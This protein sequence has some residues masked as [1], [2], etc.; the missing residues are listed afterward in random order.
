MLISF[1]SIFSYIFYYKKRKELSFLLRYYFPDNFNESF[2]EVSNLSQDIID[3]V[4]CEEWVSLFRNHLDCLFAET[5]IDRE[6][7]FNQ[8]DEEEKQYFLWLNALKDLVRQ[9]NLSN[10][11]INNN[12]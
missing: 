10:R 12:L 7:D 5:G 9:N 8:E 3:A 6:L 11:V 4:D 1:E 2:S